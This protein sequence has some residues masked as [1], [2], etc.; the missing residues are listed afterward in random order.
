M[1]DNLKLPVEEQYFDSTCEHALD[2]AMFHFRE[3]AIGDVV[4]SVKYERE[5]KERIKDKIKYSGEEN[6]KMSKEFLQKKVL[7]AFNPIIEQLKKQHFKTFEEFEKT[8]NS[9]YE[10]LI[11]TTKNVPLMRQKFL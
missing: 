8:I 4:L 5:L 2:S 7:E 1:R 10:N 11:N 6:I 9:T 3:K